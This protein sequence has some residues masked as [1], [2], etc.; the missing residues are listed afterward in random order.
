MPSSERE[1]PV[2]LQYRTDI[3]GLRAIAVL[4]VIGYHAFPEWIKGGFIGVDVFFVI[5]G[6]LITG[7]I[8]SSLENENFSYTWFYTRRIK[9][10]FPAL[11]L[12]LFA[13]LGLGWLVLLPDEFAQLGKHT[14]AGSTF[15]ANFVFWNE[16]GYFDNA[17]ATK[18]LLHLWSLGIEEQFYL[19]WPLA[20]KKWQRHKTTI[21]LCV[22]MATPVVRAALE[23]SL[24]RA[25][26]D[27]AHRR[28]AG[29]LYADGD[30]LADLPASARALP[31]A[32]RVI[33][34]A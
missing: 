27:R 10:I 9:R 33:V 5:S 1:H 26:R 21:L 34:P 4:F 24:G 22:F 15:L 32:V 19:L 13:C 17:A 20:L 14:F 8:L 12:V 30:P 29:L 6:Y 3:D 16:S 23:A 7:I 18:P 11:I 31:G 25:E 28:A 2:S